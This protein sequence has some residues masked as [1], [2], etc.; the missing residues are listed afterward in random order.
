MKNIGG[1]MLRWRAISLASILH[2]L[3]Q[4][5]LYEANESVD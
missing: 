2:A 4:E 1:N 3:I 5:E